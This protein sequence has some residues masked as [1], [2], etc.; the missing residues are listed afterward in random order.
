[1]H[2]RN[3]R[4][5]V[6]RKKIYYLVHI[7][8]HSQKSAPA[9]GQF[10]STVANRLNATTIALIPW[11]FCFFFMVPLP[12]VFIVCMLFLLERDASERIKRMKS[13][14]HSP[15]HPSKPIA[16]FNIHQRKKENFC[17]LAVRLHFLLFGTHSTKGRNKKKPHHFD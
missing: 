4:L 16:F 13:L 17:F 7:E 10:K 12:L 14:W 6:A 1:M 3:R 9:S 2:T 15:F 5:Q 11:H 8:F